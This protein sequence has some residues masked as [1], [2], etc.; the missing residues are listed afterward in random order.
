VVRSRGQADRRLL[1]SCP[2]RCDLYQSLT[3]C[4]L[5]TFN[6]SD[7]DLSDLDLNDVDLSD[8]VSVYARDVTSRPSRLALG[9][10]I[11]SSV[12]VD[13]LIGIVTHRRMT[14]CLTNFHR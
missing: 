12:T 3:A 2:Y 8:L 1:K 11:L 7:L 14:N 9:S 13:V 4:I 10:V 6:V 5:Q